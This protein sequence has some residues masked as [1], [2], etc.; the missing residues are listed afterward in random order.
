V[1]RKKREEV[2]MRAM[3]TECTRER[4]P[5]A[6]GKPPDSLQDA[7]HMPAAARDGLFTVRLAQIRASLLEG[8]NGIDSHASAVSELEAFFRAYIRLVQAHPAVARLLR[9][10]EIRRPPLRVQV[11]IEYEGFLEWLRQAIATGVRRGSIRDD[12]DP[13]PLALILVGMLEALTT[14]WLL[15]DYAFPLEEAAKAAWQTFRALIAPRAGDHGR[16]AGATP[17]DVQ[18]AKVEFR[19]WMCGGAPRRGRSPNAPAH[20]AAVSAR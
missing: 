14:R 20:P 5:E 17:P 19:T 8:A 11:R 12:L 6:R 18:R 2:A 13:Q 1:H 10:S 7:R 3:E 16:A 9:S 15:S 4:S